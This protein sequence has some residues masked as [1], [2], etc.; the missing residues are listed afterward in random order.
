[1]IE[2]LGQRQR[3][4]PPSLPSTLY[5]PAFTGID[6]V[7]AGFW[8]LGSIEQKNAIDSVMY[9]LTALVVFAVLLALR[10]RR[11]YFQEIWF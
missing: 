4:I 7:S 1:M 6:S 2:G 11:D 10:K 3:K 5:S 8:T 9:G